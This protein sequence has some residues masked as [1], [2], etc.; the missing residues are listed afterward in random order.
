VIMRFIF[1]TT[2]GVMKSACEVF[3]QYLKD[4][5][6]RNTRQ[7]ED[8]LGTFLKTDRHVTVG[9][10]CELVR[11]KY[12]KIGLA[13]IYRTMGVIADAGLARAVDFGEGMV[14][15]E[16]GYKHEHH[17]H[18]VCADCGRLIEVRSPEIEKLQADLAK[19]HGFEV[20]WHRLEIFGTC[21][22]CRT[23]QRR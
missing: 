13:T 15:F 3:R 2:G 6:L 8:I 9:E 11:E 23:K 22:Q 20:E 1:D 19:R 7:R 10:L 17:D 16:H 18:L 5:G 21:R 14:R 4:N 12:P